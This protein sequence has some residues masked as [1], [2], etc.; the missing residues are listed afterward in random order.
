M[1]SLTEF[2][3]KN[4]RL[5]VIFVMALA[6]LGALIYLD[7]PRQEDPAITVREAIVTASFPGMATSRVED[8]ITRP[9]EQAVRELPEVDE[10]RSDS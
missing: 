10:I 9:I 4:S 6:I 5:T 3:L 8:L 1:G 2:A 7:Y